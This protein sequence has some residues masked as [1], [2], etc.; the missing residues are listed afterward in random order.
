MQ[1]VRGDETGR[2][3][4]RSAASARYLH[5][6]PA[7]SRSDDT[8]STVHVLDLARQWLVFSSCTFYGYATAWQ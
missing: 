4:F 8:A 6:F 1:L 3:I 2:N 7:I 5:A